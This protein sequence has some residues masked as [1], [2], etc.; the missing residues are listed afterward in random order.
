MYRYQHVN[1]KDNSAHYN[2]GTNWSK[3]QHGVPQG[4]VQ[5]PL[6][7]LVYI[8]DLP[9]AL[10][11]SVMPIPFADDTSLIVMDKNLDILDTKLS[12]NLQIAYNWFKSNLLS[13]NSLRH[14]VCNL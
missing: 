4:S 5:G 10:D 3:I 7:F 12:A 14:I 9:L 13:I 11:E 1:L 2:L 8:N 6:L